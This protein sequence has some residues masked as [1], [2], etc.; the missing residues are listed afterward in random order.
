MN[1]LSPL[2]PPPMTAHAQHSRPTRAIDTEPTVENTTSGMPTGSEDRAAGPGQKPNSAPTPT[3]EMDFAKGVI[4]GALGVSPP[5][6]SYTQEERLKRIDA[7]AG[8]VVTQIQHIESGEEGESNIRFQKTRQFLEP[9]GY[10]S[11]GILA[12]GLDPHEKI[13]VTF[14]AYVGKWKPE[15]K[16]DTA[17]ETR[18]YFAWEIAA[19]ALKHDRPAGGGLFNFQTME[20]QP[21]DRSKINDLEALGAKLQDHWKDEIAKPMSDESGALAKRSGKA[22]A[23]V[24]K[25][26]LQGLRNDKE[27]YKTLTPEGQIAVDRTLDKNGNVLIPNIYGYPLANYAFIPYVNYHGNYDT[28]PNQGLMIDLKNGTVSEIHGDDE[29]ARWAGDN[30]DALRASF[31]AQDKQGGKDAHWPPAGN[32]LD[33]FI[34]GNHAHY[35]GRNNLLSDKQ[36]PVRETFNYTQSRKQSYHLKFGNLKSGIAESYRVLNTNNAKWADQTEVF[37]SSQQTWKEAKELWGR[38][39]GYVP[40]LGNAGNIYFGVH[41]SIYGMT[42]DDRVGGTAAA[43][44]SGLQLAHELAPS[45]AEAGLGEPAVATRASTPQQYSWKYNEQTSDFEFVRAPETSNKADT[46]ATNPASTAVIP[47]TKAASSFPG[48]QEIEFRGETYFVADTPDA[49]DGTAFLLRVK[50]RSDPTQLV[51]SGIIATPDETGVWKRAGSTGGGRWFWER[52]ITSTVSDESL[53]TPKFSERFVESDGSKILGAEKF[54]DYLNIDD[55]KEYTLTNNL[56]SD[57]SNV[58]RKLTVSWKI[59]DGNFEVTEGER[60]RF[61]ADYDGEY[62]TSFPVDLNRGD[63]TIIT[64]ENGNEVRTKLDFR[65]TSDEETIKTR[66]AKLE[67]TIPDPNLRARISEIAH[68]GASFPA[69]VELMPPVLKDGYSVSAGEK[70]FNI[71]Y[72]PATDTHTVKATTKWSLKLQTEDGGITNR[73]L[74]ITST[75]IFTIRASNDVSGDGYVIDKSAP[76]KI[77]LSTPAAV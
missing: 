46:N 11:G 76:T 56:Y 12:A 41:D 65:S 77:E 24:V 45:L 50:D 58:K 47:P 37:G 36:V 16:D 4:Y 74:D 32:V 27:I 14:N 63:Y 1:T 59:D 54:D 61:L 75:R 72:N 71:E 48:M 17:T 55:N 15:V 28:R 35:P 29:F 57:G 53:S 25:G 40:I 33:N 26:I 2:L 73:D 66:L 68:Q 3:H 7:Y 22:D 62:S 30:R 69:F 31:N 39:F 34:A 5:T 70:Y 20:I 60:A 64:K 42:A 13:T 6:A 18:T 23:Y 9:A 51:S 38:T 19:G 52:P 21:Q 49:W 44:I 10:F 8:R 43:V 67:A